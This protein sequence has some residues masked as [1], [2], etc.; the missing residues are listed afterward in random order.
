M[1]LI[2]LLQ[3]LWRN[4]FP[5]LL[6]SLL[7][8]LAFGLFVYLGPR[9]YEMRLEYN[10]KMDAVSYKKTVD[11]LYSATNIARLADRLEAAGHRELPALLRAAEG[12]AGLEA[13]VSLAITP[14][15]V[16]FRNKEKLKLS[17]E[18]SWADNIIKLEQLEAELV[19][20]TL[21]GGPA[22]ELE[23]LAA[24][25]RTN[26]ATELPLYDARD[27]RRIMTT[28]LNARL[29]ELEGKHA[30]TAQYLETLEA[31]LAGVRQLRAREPAS[32]RPLE[33]QLTAAELPTAAPY[34]PLAQQITALESEIVRT[35][36]NIAATER[37]RVWLTAL[38]DE[39]AALLA[40]LSDD[41]VTANGTLV[42]YRDVVAARI[43]ASDDVAVA[44]FLRAH[45]RFLDNLALA[46]EAIVPGGKASPLPRGT[47]GKTV[48][49]AI[50]LLVIG[51]VVV[52]LREYVR[53]AG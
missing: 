12:R 33:L 53:R 2:H 19:T 22:T 36:E 48:L 18:R 31:T 20:I 7:P 35:R 16:D 3:A 29:A 52:A 32:A 14:G 23:A 1:E 42:A 5:L 28:A 39:C 34:L 51:I 9:A 10:L 6:A 41:P 27:E 49:A 47:V 30:E 11:R 43:E 37:R 8:A 26:M 4:R 40:R 46:R 25:L 15:Y 50:V 13:I 24:S 17:L 44:D 45:L 38:L 21:R